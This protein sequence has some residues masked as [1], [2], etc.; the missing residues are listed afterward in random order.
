M[1]TY[2]LPDAEGRPWQYDRLATVSD[3]TTGYDMII[4]RVTPPPAIMDNAC[5]YRITVHSPEGGSSIASMTS[6]TLRTDGAGI[7]FKDRLE[8]GPAQPL[9]PD[10]ERVLRTA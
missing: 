5:W 3:T 8:S 2:Y 9:E 10:V 6:K 7:R 1:Q 4:E